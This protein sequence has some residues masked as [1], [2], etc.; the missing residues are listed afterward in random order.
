M[1]RTFSRNTLALAVSAASLYGSV[2]FAEELKQKQ[3]PRVLEE[4]IVTGQKI[5]TSLQDTKESVAV[6]T[7]D[8]LEQRN[9][10]DLGDVFQQTPGVSG[11]QFSFR[12]RGVRSSDGASQ[13][14]RGDLASVVIDGVTASGWVKSEAVGQLWDVSQVEVLRGPQS[15][16]LGRNALAG[17]VVLNT[18]DPVYENEGKVRV[19]YSNYGGREYKGFANVNLVDGVSALRFSVEKSE[20]DGFINNITRKEKDYGSNDN[21]V[22]RMKWLFEPSDDLKML[23]SYQRLENDYRDSRIILGQYDRDERVSINDADAIFETEADLA[24][25]NLDYDISD[26]WS[27]KSISAYQNGERYRFSDND[28]TEKAPGEGGIEVTRNSKDKNWS[29]ELRFNF[30]GENIRGSSGVYYTNIQ[31]DRGGSSDFDINLVA[32]LNAYAQTQNIP[33]PLGTLLTNPL[34]LEPFFGPGAPTLPA[35]YPAFIGSQQSG[36]TDVETTSWAVFSEWE[37]D[38]DDAWT[39][40]FGVRYDNEEQ[41]YSTQSA[42]ISTTTLPDPLGAPLGTTPIPGVGLTLDSIIG[43]VNT[44]LAAF[45]TDVPQTSKTKD[46]DN[47]LPHAG[48][49]YRWNDDVSSSFFVKKSY[50]SGGTELTLLNG[51]NE[52]EEE[53]LWAYE[54]AHRSIVFDGDGVFNANLYYSDWKDQQV[55]IQEPGTTA[56]GFYVTV[57]AGESKLYGAELS[58]SYDVNE[59]LS[60]YLGGALSKTKYENFVAPDGSGNYKGNSFAFA[61]EHTAVVGLSYQDVS[62]LFINPSISYEGCSYSDV[63]NTEEY[64]LSS[65]TLANISAG[66]EMDELKVEVFAKNLFDRTY[67]TNKALQAQDNA[68]TQVVRLGDPRVAGVRLTMDF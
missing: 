29:Q 1:N 48:L 39:A 46:F 9:L 43:L 10:T 49:T 8:T 67:E 32:Q 35:I 28:I 63:Q 24:S 62:G 59:D 66:Y 61:P 21:R 27:L 20:S 52:F 68:R 4:V 16:N 7:E 33:F 60:M 41:K 30:D 40:S 65:R 54:F 6:F 53:E 12:I 47:I 25:F 58:F 34:N 45:T 38:L 51:I 31:A 23:L 36:F 14:N 3:E 64:E 2:A 5:E 57:N 55:N 18:N 26:Q 17:A 56:P 50:R 22:Y 11:D 19:G 44:Q 15:T 13:P 37:A 42:T